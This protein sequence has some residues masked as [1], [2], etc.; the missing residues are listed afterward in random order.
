[1][2][3]K[4]FIG[5]SREGI[6]IAHAIH[7]NLTRD[8]ECTVW[9]SGVFQISATA[10]HSLIETLRQSDFAIFVFSPDDLTLMRGSINPMVRDNVIFEMGLFVGRL[11]IE[12]CF[13][14]SPDEDHDL[15][16]PTDLMGVTPG[17][18]ESSRR[19]KNWLAATN[20]VC[21]QIRAKLAEQ[22]SFQDALVNLNPPD[23]TETPD[24]NQ[25]AIDYTNWMIGTVTA[26][27]DQQGYGFVENEKRQSFYLHTTKIFVLHQPLAKNDRVIFK[28]APPLKPGGSPQAI[29]AYVLDAPVRGHIAS[30][31]DRGYGF[32]KAYSPYG[33][34]ADLFILTGTDH[35]LKR[36]DH[37][38]CL[39]SS[40]QT[41]PIG[42]DIRSINE[43]DELVD[44][45]N[46]ID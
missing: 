18:Y 40:N 2:K 35:S 46:N 7:A 17:K 25:P 36:D 12:R 34:T 39:I 1:M 45:S 16:L 43:G 31:N 23:I 32:M 6:D 9:T 24:I 11:G 3:P 26:W 38:E 20:P 21:M 29:D 4:V 8:A 14:I 42:I 41:G 5:S 44:L 28:P 33:K 30:L 10:I 22:K 13:F 27:K 19:D 15:R 37:I